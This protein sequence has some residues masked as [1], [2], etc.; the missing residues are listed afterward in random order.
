M[1]TDFSAMRHLTALLSGW[2]FAL[3]LGIS[4]MTRPEKVIGFLDVFGNWDP[5][6][7]WVMGGAVSLTLLLFA[8]ILRRPRPVLES[9]FHVPVSRTIDRRLVFGASLFGIGW[10]LSGYC[11]GPALASLVVLNPGT[12]VFVLFLLLGLGLCQRYAN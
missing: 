8:P 2:L 10:G 12:V 7:L 4:G 9:R 11:P 6:L 3:G 5:S 1:F